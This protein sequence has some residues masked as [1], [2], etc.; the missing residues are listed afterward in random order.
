VTLAEFEKQTGP[1]AA[2]VRGL[3]LGNAVVMIGH[4]PSRDDYL[5]ALGRLVDYRI[6]S[7]TDRGQVWLTKI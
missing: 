3:I 5:A 4:G 6:S 2:H 1:Q 7:T